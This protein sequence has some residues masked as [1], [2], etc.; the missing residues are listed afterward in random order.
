MEKQ[1]NRLA[2]KSQS[3]FP[4]TRAT[5]GFESWGGGRG[6]DKSLPEG[7]GKWMTPVQNPK[8]PQP[9][10]LVG[11]RKNRFQK[12]TQQKKRG[13]LP[14]ARFI[15]TEKVINLAPSW[16]PNSIKNRLK[17]N[18]KI[19]RFF[20]ASWGRF[21]IGFWWILESKMEPSWHQNRS[22][23]DANCERR[24]FEK[25]CSGCSLGSIFVILGVE[26]GS[27]NRLKID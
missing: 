16:T 9:R 17:I 2:K 18:I 10:G 6:R 24:F 14:Q 11:F 27:E 15:L 22:K 7:R 13:G 1:K 19:D 21:L 26:V 3:E 5:P 20:D 8:P 25:S 23:I 4:T 12:N